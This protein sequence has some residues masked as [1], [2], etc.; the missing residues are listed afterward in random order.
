MFKADKNL[1]LYYE[2]ELILDYV[3]SKDDLDLLDILLVK[4]RTEGLEGKELREV[5]RLIESYLPIEIECDCKGCYISNIIN[6]EKA[7]TYLPI[8]DIVP[9]MDLRREIRKTLQEV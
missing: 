3:E 8:L 5:V 2:L 4:F 6:G 9:T 7:I 1:G